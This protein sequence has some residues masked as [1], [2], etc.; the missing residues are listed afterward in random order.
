MND[1]VLNQIAVHFGPM[2]EV[3]DELT[4]QTIAAVQED[5]TCFAGGAKWRSRWIMR[6]SVISFSITDEDSR[7]SAEAIIDAWQKVRSSFR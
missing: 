7:K 4:K 3:G 6:L 2:S 1:V 5:G